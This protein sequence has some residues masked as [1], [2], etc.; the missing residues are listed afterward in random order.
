MQQKKDIIDV[1]EFDILVLL[2]DD[3]CDEVKTSVRRSKITLEMKFDAVFSV[4]LA[5]RSTW[6]KSL[7]APCPDTGISMMKV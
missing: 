5:K 3:I 7:F 4:I 2:E 6:K 1:I